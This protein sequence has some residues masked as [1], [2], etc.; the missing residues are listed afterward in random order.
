MLLF[1]VIYDLILLHNISYAKP[2]ETSEWEDS[3]KQEVIRLHKWQD[4]DLGAVILL[5]IYLSKIIPDI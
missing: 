5:K 1:A 4:G 3:T 2:P